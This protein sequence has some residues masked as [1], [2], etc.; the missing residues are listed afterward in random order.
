MSSVE[1]ECE[2]DELSSQNPRAYRAYL[3]QILQAKFPDWDAEEWDMSP[4]IQQGA[5]LTILRAQS[6]RR[7]SPL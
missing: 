2:Q 6:S 3:L 7:Y 5:L 1:S 4:T